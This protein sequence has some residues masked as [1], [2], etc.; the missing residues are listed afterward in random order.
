[1]P[2]NRLGMAEWLFQ[3]SSAHQP[4]HHESLLADVLWYGN[5]EDM[6]DFGSQGEWPSH[7]ELL[8]WLATEFMARHWTSSRC[9]RQSSCRATT[10]NRASSTPTLLERTVTTVC[11]RA[12]LVCGWKQNLCVTTRWPSVVC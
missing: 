4:R 7:P 5:R 3:Q 9:L 10:G 1:M 11:S 6:N 2:T 8:D 12:D